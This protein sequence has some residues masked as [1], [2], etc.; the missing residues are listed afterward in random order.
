MPV[1]HTAGV[2]PLEL[3]KLDNLTS[4]TIGANPK[5]QCKHLCVGRYVHALAKPF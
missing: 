5:L 4:F 2:T 3:T 1:S